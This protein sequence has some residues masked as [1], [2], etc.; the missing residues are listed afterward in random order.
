MLILEIGYV[1]L[2]FILVAP[3]NEV[4]FEISSTIHT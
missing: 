4:V 2:I 1:E 3:S